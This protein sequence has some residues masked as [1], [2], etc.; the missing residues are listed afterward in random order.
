[1]GCYGYAAMLILSIATA[2]SWGITTGDTTKTS[3]SKSMRS[4][5]YLWALALGANGK[6]NPTRTCYDII[7]RKVKSTGEGW[8]LLKV[9]GWSSNDRFTL[10]YRSLELSPSAGIEEQELLPLL[11][12]DDSAPSYKV[13]HH[14]SEKGLQLTRLGFLTCTAAKRCSKVFWAADLREKQPRKPKW[15][16]MTFTRAEKSFKGLQRFRMTAMT[17]SFRSFV[18]FFAKW[19]PWPPSYHLLKKAILSFRSSPNQHSLSLDSWK[20]WY[21]CSNSAGL[22]CGEK[23]EILPRPTASIEKKT[24]GLKC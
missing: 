8:G 18:G 12:K 15:D 7:F 5:G 4:I 14:C 19:T 10:L 20:S 24:V 16:R 21:M 9:G 2:I 22:E 1:M 11:Q 3:M 6:R 17:C 13:L 23:H